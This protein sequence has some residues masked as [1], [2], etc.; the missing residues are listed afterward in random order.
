MCNH[1]CTDQLV[2]CCSHRDMTA[3]SGKVEQSLEEESQVPVT[4]LEQQNK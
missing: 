4:D 3:Q 2:D 1:V